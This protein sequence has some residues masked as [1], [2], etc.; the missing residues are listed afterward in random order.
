[1][2]DLVLLSR[3]FSQ[4]SINELRPQF[5]FNFLRVNCISS[6]EASGA[7]VFGQIWH[8]Q[9]NDATEERRG[10]DRIIQSSGRL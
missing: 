3:V 6:E 8:Q 7:A 4:Y 1:M 9:L 5:A 10:M 2:T